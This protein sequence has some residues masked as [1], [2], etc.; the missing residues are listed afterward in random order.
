MGLPEVMA[1]ISDS[2]FS[3]EQW[4]FVEDTIALL[5]A[6]ETT[7]KQ[8]LDLL[9]GDYPIT[10]SY[11]AGAANFNNLTRVLSIDPDLVYNALTADGD[12][13]QLDFA[14]LLMHELVHATQT[15]ASEDQANDPDY[16][17]TTDDIGAHN[18]RASFVEIQ[19]AAALG[20]ESRVSYWG[21]YKPADVSWSDPGHSLTGGETVH[22][23]FVQ[24]TYE[25]QQLISRTNDAPVALNDLIVGNQL[26]NLVRGGGGNDHL[27]GGEGSD[28]IDGGD[29][30][31]II[32]G[33]NPDAATNSASEVDIADYSTSDGSVL[34]DLTSSKSTDTAK[35][36]LQRI[37]ISDDG[38]GSEDEL[39]GIDVIELS[40]EDDNVKADDKLLSRKVIIDMAAGDGDELDVSSGASGV[41]IEAGIVDDA[42]DPHGLNGSVYV[43]LDNYTG[44]RFVGLELII[45]TG[46][47]DTIDLSG[48]RE[49][50]S[51]VGIEVKGGGGID[52]ITGGSGDD[53]LKGEAEGDILDGGAGGDIID[54]GSGDDTVTYASAEAGVVVDLRNLAQNTGDA[55][56]D[57]YIDIE[58]IEGSSFQ[59]DLFGGSNNDVLAGAAGEDL[60]AGGAGNDALLGGAGDD[61]YTGGTLIGT[62]RSGLPAAGGTGVDGYSDEGVDYFFD[63]SG[64]D[65]YLFYSHNAWNTPVG[66][67]YL[68]LIDDLDGQ[69]RIN[70]HH[71]VDHIEVS[72]DYLIE[73]AGFYW[74]DSSV[75]G[76]PAGSRFA[77][78]FDEEYTYV[79][80]TAILTYD[81]N[82]VPILKLGTAHN[83]TGLF[84]TRSVEIYNFYQGDFGIFLQYYYNQR[85]NLQGDEDDNTLGDPDSGANELYGDGGDDTYLYVNG[86]G[87]DRVVEKNYSSASSG[88]MDTLHVSGILPSQ[89][90]VYQTNGGLDLQI[91]LV[92][93]SQGVTV[94]GGIGWGDEYRVE[95]VRFDDGTIISYTD[96]F[97]MSIIPTAGDDA[98]YGDDFDNNLI[99]G[100]GNDYLDGRY[101]ND[102]L[103]GDGGDDAYFFDVGYGSDWILERDWSATS[104]GG[105]DTLEFGDGITAG[106]LVVRQ[107]EDGLHL[108][109]EIDGTSDS[110]T[111]AGGLGWGEDYR[112]EEIVFSD[113]STLSY[114]DLFQL[115]VTP[116]SGDDTFYGDDFDNTL[117]GG[118]G[119][120]RLEARFGSDTLTG[121]LDA[122]T[123][124][125]R[126]DDGEDV[127]TDFSVSGGD[128]IELIGYAGL[129]DFIDLTALLVE[130]GGSTFIEFD[131]D[132]AIEIDNVAMA[133]LSADDFRFVA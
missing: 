53:T 41:T 128:I 79:H 120:D 50:V 11:S 33:G 105:F 34:V 112:L 100:L 123:F 114:T 69:G 38:Y 95:Q 75:Y 98:F 68:D 117:V 14:L 82:N 16:L 60:L 122:D 90:V 111:I 101:G 23:V 83:D 8:Y 116:T 132:N 28:R 55:E 19:V 15:P 67:Q 94:V 107:A 110:L 25:T 51:P 22:R 21:G 87:Y 62:E 6:E 20:L 5:Y 77:H 26:D 48:A 40:S 45:G 113:T 131:N 81:E 13:K 118:A 27:Y 59:D 57:T 103:S 97:A 133:S 43:A 3:P 49:A 29:G 56:G 2:G 80:S 18:S 86:N 17:N 7:A 85:T 37:F 115:S 10:I 63:E 124:V 32:Y 46:F 76:E 39:Y 35:E 126:P 65:T 74:D 91:D 102:D 104:A 92:G 31:D 70:I 125:F 129:D 130:V 109:I 89:V 58:V 108:R 121:G 24:R 66:T 73:T 1:K 106:D 12:I 54:G 119:E 52:R 42:N 9:A 4:Q 127:I 47:A 88:G 61:I 72:V 44:T 71:H 84:E 30:N 93:Y 99:G 36:Q 78:Q 96:L 64:Y